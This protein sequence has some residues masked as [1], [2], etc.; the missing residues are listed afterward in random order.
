M[1]S[2][3]AAGAAVAAALVGAGAETASGR[4]EA[5][6]TLSARPTVVSGNV[7]LVTLTGAIDSGREGETVTIQV[8]DCGLRSYTGVAS[9]TT[10]AGGSFIA[11]LRPGISTSIRAAWKGATSAPVAV[12]K[13][14][15]ITLEQRSARRFEVGISGKG[16]F[17]RKKVLFQRRTGGKWATVKTVVLTETAGQPGF[18]YVRSSAE[19]TASVPKGSQV[20]VVL[21]LSQAK[22]CYLAATSAPIRT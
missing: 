14:P 8:K 20:R 19:F 22:P 17:W 13:V 12:K 18:A 7:G 10:R 6:V 15:V 11:E 21:P 4:V 2:L 3:L 9:A 1:K 5:N 16:Q